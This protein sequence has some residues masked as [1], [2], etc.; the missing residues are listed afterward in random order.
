[1]SFIHLRK[2]GNDARTAACIA[3]NV[4]RP[5]A[6]ANSDASSGLAHPRRRLTMLASP[7][8]A[9]SADAHGADTRGQASISA[10]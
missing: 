10:S 4:R 7:L 6:F 2:S 1:L 8:I 3:S 5:T 9:F